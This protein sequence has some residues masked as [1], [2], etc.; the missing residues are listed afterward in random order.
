MRR[1]YAGAIGFVVAA[2]MGATVHAQNFTPEQLDRMAQERQ[3]EIGPRN[4][5]PPPPVTNETYVKRSLPVAVECK[6][7]RRDFEPLYA[8]PS[9][10]SVR[11]GVAAPQI[12]VTSV[13]SKGWRKVLRVGNSFAWIPDADVVPYQPLV[14]GNT[15]RCVVAGEAANGMILFDHPA[16]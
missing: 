4:W 7:P 5:G 3:K 13:V 16:K 2:M 10:E 11:V 12:A 14:P 9:L 1:R 8:E 6:S 15:T